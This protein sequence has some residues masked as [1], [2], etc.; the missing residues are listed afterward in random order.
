MDQLTSTTV[1]MDNTH[2]DD[3]RNQIIGNKDNKSNNSENS[4]IQEK[5]SPESKKYTF[6]KGE[7]TYDIDDDAEIEIM[8]DKRPIRLTLKEL[9]DRAAGDIAVKNRMH[10]LAE[11][12]KRV[13][14]TLKQFAELSRSDPLAALE[15]ISN[16]AK[17]ADGDFEYNKYLEKLA[18]QAEKLGQMDEKER[19]AMELE[20]KLNKAESDLSLKERETLAIRRKQDILSDYPEIGDQQFGQMVDAVLNNEDLLEGINDENG[21]LDKV[22][23]LIQETLTQRDIITVIKEINPA[24]SN[25]NDLIFSLSDQIRQ[26]PDLDEED[27]RDIIREIIRPEQN[28]NSNVRQ[29]R[30]TERQNDV[31]T[32]SQKQRQSVPSNQLRSQGASEFDVLKMQ[33]LENKEKNS[34]TPLYMR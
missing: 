14:N 33:L 28:S 12:K 13:S 6:K 21:V 25:D 10:S 5:K 15:F 24:Y 23:D 34:R 26:N 3:L 30:T 22:E 16:K 2:F 11:E 32:L 4:P 29:Y 19:K 20:K 7:N 27:I 17:E 9:K 18:D 8:A 1:E 31:R